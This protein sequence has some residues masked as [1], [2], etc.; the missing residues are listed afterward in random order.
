MQTPRTCHERTR[1]WDPSKAELSSR[2]FESTP[3]NFAGLAFVCAL[4]VITTPMENS[5]ASASASRTKFIG[6]CGVPFVIFPL[7]RVRQHYAFMKTSSLPSLQRIYLLISP[8]RTSLPCTLAPALFRRQRLGHEERAGIALLGAARS[9]RRHRSLLRRRIWEPVGLAAQHSRNGVRP[10]A[11]RAR[12][13][14]HGR[15]QGA[16]RKWEFGCSGRQYGIFACRRLELIKL[17]VRINDGCMSMGFQGG[18]A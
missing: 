15:R 4:K 14:T 2:R 18:R 17:I 12:S 6:E 7:P 8:H 13:A 11:E 1:P 16:W 10:F 3:E 5:V 9:H